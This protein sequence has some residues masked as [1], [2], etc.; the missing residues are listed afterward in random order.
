MSALYSRSW[1]YFAVLCSHTL[2]GVADRASVTS[3]F[4]GLRRVGLSFG[5]FW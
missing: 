4:N 2:H 1:S 5:P 3:L